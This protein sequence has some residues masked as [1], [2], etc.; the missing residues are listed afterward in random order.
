MIKM[1]RDPDD[2]RLVDVFGDARAGPVTGNKASMSSSNLRLLLLYDLL[3]REAKRQKL[4]D[5]GVSILLS[6]ILK[7]SHSSGAVMRSSVSV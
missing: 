7:C 3:S 4:N 1:A 2:E 6:S 5:F